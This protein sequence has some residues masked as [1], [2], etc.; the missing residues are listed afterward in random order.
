MNY[1]ITIDYRQ[2]C[3]LVEALCNYMDLRMPDVSAEDLSTDELLEQAA[4]EYVENRYSKYEDW[5]RQYKLPDKIEEFKSLR[6]LFITL[7]NVRP[8]RTET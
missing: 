2:K 8:T 3:L 5:F 6:G 7:G 1:T 4:K